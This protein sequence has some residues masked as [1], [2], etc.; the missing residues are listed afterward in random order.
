VTPGTSSRADHRYAHHSLLVQSHGAM[1]VL[2]VSF[3]ASPPRPNAPGV[4]AAQHLDRWMIDVPSR[5]RTGYHIL[6]Q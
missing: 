4:T 6:L 5:L 2:T 3:P 1:G